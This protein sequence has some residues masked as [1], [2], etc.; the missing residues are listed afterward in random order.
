M[1]TLSNNQYPCVSRVDI[2]ANVF[3]VFYPSFGS[4]AWFKRHELA[5]IKY[6]TWNNKKN[7]TFNLLSEPKLDT[8]WWISPSLLLGPCCTGCPA[9]CWCCCGPFPLPP[10]SGWCC[11]RQQGRGSRWRCR[12]YWICRTLLWWLAGWSACSEDPPC[13]QIAR[14]L[15]WKLMR[16]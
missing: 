3:L 1:V 7:H 13:L 6:S 4:L 16:Y 8:V 15:T 14:R 12:R 5:M 11:C 9:A 10:S 2:T